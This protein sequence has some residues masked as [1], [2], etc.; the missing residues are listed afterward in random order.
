MTT[1]VI[2]SPATASV[3]TCLWERTVDDAR[4]V[5]LSGGLT[6]VRWCKVT[7]ISSPSMFTML[8]VLNSRT[9]SIVDEKSY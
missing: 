4:W 6:V 9:S 3:R 5:W 1:V 7:N 2:L 8:G